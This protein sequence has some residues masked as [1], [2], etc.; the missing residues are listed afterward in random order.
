[1]PDLHD[2]RRA[3][4]AL[5]GTALEP[6]AP[7]LPSRLVV[8]PTRAAG[9]TLA[10]TLT[11]F[12]LADLALP[13]CVTRDR[14]YDELHRRLAA[15]P[16]R[17]SPFERDAMAQAAA[18]EAARAAEHLPFQVR[19]GLVAEL[20]RFYD[21]LRRQSQQVRRF[22]ELIVEALGGGELVDTGADRLLVQTRFLARTFAGYEARAAASDAL[23]E[24]RLRE[25]LL[26][27]TAAVP[28]AHVVVT[29]PDWIADPSGLF[30]AD[31]DLLSQLPHLASLDI[32][33]TEG[34][35][36]SG[37]HE[38]LHQWWPGLEELTSRDLVAQ[39]PP[40]RPMLAVPPPTAD[41]AP[42]WF[43]HRDREEELNV[44]ARRLAAAPQVALD[45]VA[46]VFKKP[47]P[48]LYLA[49]DTLGAA[50]LPF[51]AADALPLAAEPLVATVD[52]LLDALEADFA[53]D[54]LVALLRSPHFEWSGRLG[55]DA[56]GALDRAL[57]D[58]R[59][60]GTAAR[61]RTLG[62]GWSPEGGARSR[63]GSETRTTARP[64]LDAVLDLVGELEPLRAARPASVQV[65]GVLAFLERHLVSRDE[66]D[67]PGAREVRARR[68]VLQLLRGVADAHAQHHDPEWSV[69][70]LATAV[71]RW[72]GDETFATDGAMSGVRLLDDQAARYGDFDDLTIVGLVESD[73]PEK[74][75][76]NIFYPPQLL[77]ALGWP[78]EK[79]RRGAADA[80]FLDLLLSARDRV[81]LSAFLLDDEAIV[82]RTVQLD[83][84]PR[85]GL[86]TVPAPLLDTPWLRDES[87]ALGE[88]PADTVSDPAREW[89]SVR[90]GRVPA[91]DPRFHG[92]VGERPSRT[93]SVSALEA[94]LGCPFKFYAQ[95][96]LR[97]E[98]EPDDEEVMDPRRQGQFIHEVFETFFTEWQ[99]TGHRAITHANLPLARERF[100]SVVDRAL[101]RIPEGEAAL[102]RTRLLGSPAAAGLGEAV[103]RMEAER[104]VPV[105]ER[106]LEHT[107]DGPVTLQTES[108]P[109]TIELR[110]KADRIDLLADGT[111]R[112][113]DYKLGWPPDRSRALQLP[114][115]AVCAEQHLR[116]RGRSWVLGEAV[117]LAF[118][119]PKRVVPL[120][121]RENSREET[122]LRAQQR[123]VD[124][125]DAIGRGEF[126]PTP[127][128]VY[129]C[130]TC[131]FTA[132]CR[133]DYVGDL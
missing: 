93:W 66:A 7:G 97:L 13:A 57:S 103:F 23:D 21:Q 51:V 131:S 22:E 116:V 34:V 124:T 46:V 28:V 85:A 132:V 75:R 9:D 110:G 41:A 72:I 43:T 12:G 48:Y 31:F 121:A 68:T 83:E 44:V 91:A 120:F 122:L 25:R 78:S 115:Y 111:F 33:S 20:M 18:R 40:V 96:V 10:R 24:H 37:F 16:R 26:A 70:D 56:I 105:V 8:V 130:E 117:Y 73:W 52:L 2:F 53:R 49:A 17:L 15:P 3:I 108:G 54:T 67:A 80:R 99:A 79:D 81:E 90:K 129:R 95:H 58:A 127:D 42:L 113:I 29:V 60:L 88:E 64:A 69:A 133:K 4:A 89:L 100:V 112:L 27:D 50:G 86:S 47:L 104:P 102:E 30:V 5:C 62:D 61:L 109:R 6:A 123:V 36:A 65:S 38:R 39:R 125:L 119:G 45:R 98:E 118:K 107:L 87:L 77:K 84:V 76:R 126:P 32:V 35:L 63:R 59:Y 55:R 128:D 19:P 71:R 14:L 101:T 114:I 82:S 106:L 11:G 74:P 1:M 94:Y 92:A